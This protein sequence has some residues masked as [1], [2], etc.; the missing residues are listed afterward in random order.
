MNKL[1]FALSVFALVPLLASATPQAKEI[2]FSRSCNE[3]VPVYSKDSG[4][5]G[6][7]ALKMGGAGYV[8]EM[9][10]NADGTAVCP[11]GFSFIG[12]VAGT[13]EGAGYKRYACVK[14]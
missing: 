6:C 2:A 14:E 3:G 10:V 11:K 7:G 13:Q 9:A 5:V 4:S 1:I 8:I 12:M